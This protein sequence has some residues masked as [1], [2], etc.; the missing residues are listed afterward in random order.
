VKYTLLLLTV[1]LGAT[2]AFAQ[3]TPKPAGLPVTDEK[4]SGKF[5]GTVKGSEQKVV[6][7]LKAE[8]GRL[9]R[10]QHGENSYDLTEGTFTNNSVALIFGK[11]GKL[12]GKIDG[13]KFVG[14]VSIGTQKWPV[15]LK[16]VPAAAAASPVTP[17]TPANPATPVNLNGEWDAVAD[18]NGQPFPFLLVLKIDGE[19]VTGSSSSQLGD[20]TIKT[21]AWKEGRLVLQLEGQNGTISLTATV[22]E[23][24]LSGEYDY[25]GQLQGKWVATKKQ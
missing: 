14:D 1:L 8:Q 10:L 12:T 22:V 21:G 9:G 19:A 3:G 17:A 18:A 13:D 24:K 20:S 23:G 4:L 25:A 15:E 11:D 6:L 7:E 5:E 2:V 16:R